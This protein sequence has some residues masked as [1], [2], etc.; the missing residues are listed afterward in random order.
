MKRGALLAQLREVQ[1]RE[2]VAVL[3]SQADTLA[4]E[5]R[6]GNLKPG[7]VKNRQARIIKL[8]KEI[9]ALKGPKGGAPPPAAPPTAAPAPKPVPA[10]VV[11]R[12]PNLK[13]KP[14]EAPPAPV[15]APPV[16][17]EPPPAPPVEPPR[18]AE[19]PPRAAEAPAPVPAPEAPR[20]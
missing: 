14:A 13:A 19:A 17:V 1:A 18:P 11:P 9:I 15:E 3:Q 16:R 12:S 8:D 7:Q 20:A 10:R 6:T 4:E 5:I 2:K